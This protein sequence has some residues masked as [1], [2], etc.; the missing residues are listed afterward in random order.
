MSYAAVE[1]LTCCTHQNITFQNFNYF[2]FKLARKSLQNS[3]GNEEILIQFVPYI[4]YDIVVSSGINYRTG[5]LSIYSNNLQSN[6]DGKKITRTLKRKAFQHH[7]K[8]HHLVSLNTTTT[9]L[10]TQN[11]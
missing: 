9:K 1:S 2:Q 5:E 7:F 6:A 3:P 8:A 10:R 4:N 11:K